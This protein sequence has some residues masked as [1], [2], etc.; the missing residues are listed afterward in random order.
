MAT[1]REALIV[2][3]KWLHAAY[4]RPP[5]TPECKA[6]LEKIDLALSAALDRVA[7]NFAHDDAGAQVSEIARR[8][9]L[10]APPVEQQAARATVYIQRDHLEKAKRAPFLC[11][12]EP[13]QRLPDF[14]PM[15]PTEQLSQDAEDAAR[16][17]WLR[18]RL[19]GAAY[20]IAGVIYSEGGAGVDAAV[21]AARAARAAQAQ[22]EKGGA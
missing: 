22:G 4:D 18:G 20:R 16:Y 5:Q 6:M 10:A 19:P 13:T 7:V 8:A 2:A 15:R 3:A 21:D 9:A 12:V 11:R 14:V 1:D 17:R